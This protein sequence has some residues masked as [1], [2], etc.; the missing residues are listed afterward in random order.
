MKRIIFFFAAVVLAANVNA[1]SKWGETMA[2]SVTCY[3][4]YNI[5]GSFYQ[6]KDYAGAFEPW[7]KVYQTC[8]SAKKATY[9][10]GPKIVETKIKA[11]TGPVCRMC[12]QMISLRRCFAPIR[13]DLYQAALACNRFC[14]CSAR[15]RRL[16]RT[17]DRCTW[18]FSTCARRLTACRRCGSCAC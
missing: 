9:I 15:V 16:V 7:L 1:Q 4:S 2:D 17:T 10:Y 14:S 6:S 12:A 5:F 11:T 3:E 8:P 18:C 13:Q